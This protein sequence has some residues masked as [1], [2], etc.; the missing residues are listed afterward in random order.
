MPSKNLENV[1]NLPVPWSDGSLTARLWQKNRGIMVS[2][3]ELDICCYGRSQSEAVLRLFSN[4]LKYYNELKDRD[5]LSER[6]NA[7]LKLLKVWVRGVEK[8]MCADE[9][10]LSLSRI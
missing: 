7:H 4:L 2:V 10:A 3:P 6:Q 1:W 5:D 9:S 8:K